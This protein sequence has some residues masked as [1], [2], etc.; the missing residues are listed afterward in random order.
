MFELWLGCTSAPRLLAVIANLACPALR[1]QTSC[2]LFGDC[3]FDP[4]RSQP[5]TGQV[6]EIEIFRGSPVRESDF[7]ASA[8]GD[9]FVFDDPDL[10]AR[11]LALRLLGLTHQLREQQHCE[12]CR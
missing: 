2:L 10:L 1:G 12:F 11:H 4:I 8:V 9:G 3:L 7:V 6:F 5:A